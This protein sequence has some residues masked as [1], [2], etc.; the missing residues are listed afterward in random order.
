MDF[1]TP[2]ERGATDAR[3]V[4]EGETRRGDDARV[5]GGQDGGAVGVER[6][7]VASSDGAVARGGWFGE[8]EEERRVRG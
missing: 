1:A 5:R 8:S 4:G 2:D 7:G 6:G 3:V